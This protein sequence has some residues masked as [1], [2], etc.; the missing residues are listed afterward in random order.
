[1]EKTIGLEPV[2][3][4]LTSVILAPPTPAQIRQQLE[5]I[6][7]SHTFRAAEKQKALLRYVV[8]QAVQGRSDEVKEYS[9][10][11]EAFGRGDSF[12]PRQDTIVRTEARNV[13]F[14]LARYYEQEGKHDPI[15]IQLPKGGYTPRF[16]EPAAT[17][18]APDPVLTTAPKANPWLPATVSRLR[19]GSRIAILAASVVILAGA[20]AAGYFAHF[21]RSAFVTA[22]PARDPASIAVLPFLNLTN[23]K[24]SEILSDALTEELINSLARIPG[25]HVMAGPSVFQYS[26]FRYKDQARDIAQAGRE[27]NVRSLLKGSVWVSGGRVRISAQLEDASNGYQ[28]WSESFDRKLD[29]LLAIQGEISRAIMQSLGV[30]LAGAANLKAGV[31]P[32]PAIYQDY[33]K[34]LYFLNQST[35]ENIRTAIEYFERAAASDPKFA[36][37]YRGVADGYARIA[38]FTSTPSE[39]V[40]PKIRSAA[41]KA[42]E[43]DDSLGEAHLDLARAN[44]IEWNWAAAER[45]FHRALDLSPSSAAVHHYYGEHLLRAGYSEEALAEGRIAMELDPI[46]PHSAQFV[47]RA[48][49]YLRRYDDS[50]DELQ[51]ALH[52]HPSSGISHQLLG[53]VW[54]ARSKTYPEGVRESELARKFMEADPWVT[55]QLGYAYAVTGKSKEAREVLDQLLAGSGGYV[56]ALPVARVYIGLGDRERAFEWLRKAAEQRDIS[57]MLKADPLYDDLRS[58]KRFDA[59]LRAANLDALPHPEYR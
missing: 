33:L 21:G 5:R 31:L 8:E 41:A 14:K 10:G 7:T 17:P 59:L 49:Y 3:Q 16:V 51:K 30:E 20:I 18:E 44:S 36:P 50:I 42:L 1:M 6:L 37:A 32:S 25:L 11:V 47:A 27:L 52:L 54:L 55:S 46:S 22:P 38:A 13:R 56:R 12:D 9:V 39:E 28:L 24:E 40:I 58:D 35:A 29:D 2:D 19:P 53:L 4:T 26:V 23:D 48:L 43:L 34:G 15:V 57:L 45:E